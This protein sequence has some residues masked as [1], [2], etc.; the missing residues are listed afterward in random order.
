MQNFLDKT[1][2]YIN[3]LKYFKGGRTYTFAMSLLKEFDMF[4]SGLSASAKGRNINFLNFTYSSSKFGIHVNNEDDFELIKNKIIS[5]GYV[6]YHN[7]N[8]VSLETFTFDSSTDP[9]QPINDYTKEFNECYFIYP[10]EREAFYHNTYYIE[11]QREINAQNQ[12]L[13][14][15]HNEVITKGITSINTNAYAALIKAMDNANA[16]TLA[17]TN[18]RFP[19]PVTALPIVQSEP[20]AA[21]LT[22]ED[23]K[24]Q[25]YFTHKG[26]GNILNVSAHTKLIRITQMN[27]DIEE[28]KWKYS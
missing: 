14:A 16:T 25:A 3:K 4:K 26:Y 11:L 10:N 12:L 20:V 18:A 9:G 15:S 22:P 2:K 5:L 7:S 13:T 21:E 23:K 17:L 6:L 27:K 24:L 1:Y 8:R 19:L 28:G